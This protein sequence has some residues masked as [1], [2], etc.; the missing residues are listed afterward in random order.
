LSVLNSD[1][2]YNKHGWFAGFF[3]ADGTVDYYYKGNNKPQLTVSVVNKLY[4]DVA[5]FMTN[6]GGAI[7][8]NKARNGYYK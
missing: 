3:A 2:L 7:Y 4:V 1:T 8:F 6:F 5:P